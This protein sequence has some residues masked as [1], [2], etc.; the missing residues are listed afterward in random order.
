MVFLILSR[1]LLF[2]LGYVLLL[3]AVGCSRSNSQTQSEVPLVGT[4]TRITSSS[5]SI[6]SSV[7]HTAIVD[8]IGPYNGSLI[9][10]NFDLRVL[11]SVVDSEGR[12]VFPSPQ[13]NYSM[14]LYQNGERQACLDGFDPR[15]F[16]GLSNII[17][18]KH[19]IAVHISLTDPDWPVDYQPSVIS[20]VGIVH[21]ERIACVKD[22][23]FVRV[24]D[25]LTS[26]D[27]FIPLTST[28]A[29]VTSAKLYAAHICKL[30]DL[31][32]SRLFSYVYGGTIP[33]QTIAGV[34][35]SNSTAINS[36]SRPFTP[37]R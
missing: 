26:G 3:Q 32:P 14:C 12:L 2:W 25:M 5:S 20:G 28:V 15:T 19:E 24:I 31:S 34:M 4:P 36:N 11:V 33:E 23:P 16:I 1:M 10:P 13:T 6:T 18:G 22:D 35:Y 9:G 8:I 21:V 37:S 29:Y 27:S 7:P 17:V 30:L